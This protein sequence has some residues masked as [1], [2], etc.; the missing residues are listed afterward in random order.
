MRKLPN[1]RK[2]RKSKNFFFANLRICDLRNFYAYRP[3]LV[4]RY[5]NVVV[6]LSNKIYH[7]NKSGSVK[8]DIVLFL[9]L[10]NLFSFGCVDTDTVL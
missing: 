5:G 4:S 10:R 7:G 9:F 1:L 3:P 6:V 8:Q 2:V